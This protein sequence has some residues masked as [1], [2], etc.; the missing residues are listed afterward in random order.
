MKKLG[1]LFAVIFLIVVALVGGYIYAEKKAEERFKAKVEKV[2]AET[3]LRENVKVGKYSVSLI[4]RQASL[5]DVKIEPSV[6]DYGDFLVELKVIK[7]I[8]FLEHEEDPELEIPT[9]LKVAFEGIELYIKDKKK[10]K[11]LPLSLSGLYWYTY[12]PEKAFLD[13]GLNLR[14]N[15]FEFEYGFSLKEIE[16]SLIKELNE[17]TKEEKLNPSDPRVALLFSKLLQIKP[18]KVVLRY[19]DKGFL[20]SLA[21]ISSDNPEEEIRT[22][23][24]NIEREIRKTDS[25]YLKAILSGFKKALEKGK[26]GFEI[27]FL[28]K[29]DLSIQD[30][31]A[32]FA[33]AKNPDDVTKVLSSKVEIRVKEL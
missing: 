9:S 18:E 4:K 17:I 14:G 2:L 10:G 31:V 30:F 7:R 15:L 8:S 21:E 28:N 26:G 11:E 6:E 25:P 24:A 27:V 33:M 22:A 12:Q 23:I 29:E 5:E 20:R 13:T 32:L 3:G 16:P 1:V 19:Y